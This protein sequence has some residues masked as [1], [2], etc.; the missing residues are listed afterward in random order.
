MV[1][2]GGAWGKMNTIVE[3]LE[4]LWLEYMYYAFFNVVPSGISLQG[5]FLF[6]CC[7]CAL[8]TCA[9]FFGGSC[10]VL[11][12]SIILSTSRI[13]N[14]PYFMERLSQSFFLILKWRR[15]SIL[16]RLLT[17]TD[18]MRVL[19]GQM[20]ISD[21]QAF[22]DVTDAIYCRRVFYDEKYRTT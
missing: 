12:L 1:N 20:F 19:C 10:F 13:P 7:C 9:K 4:M 14:V 6:R 21:I 17:R 5:Y 2:I 11:M 8:G 16:V 15:I 18:T 3:A 22:W